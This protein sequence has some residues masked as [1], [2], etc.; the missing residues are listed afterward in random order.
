MGHTVVTLATD[1]CRASCRNVVSTVNKVLAPANLL[2][3]CYYD[4]ISSLFSSEFHTSGISI[5]IIGNINDL[6]HV[7][8]AS[9][10]K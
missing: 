5:E 1:V 2:S 4:S 8:S 7:I 9:G 3:P 6:G 10:P